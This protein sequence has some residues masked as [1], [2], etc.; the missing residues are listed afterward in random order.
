MIR[1]FLKNLPRLGVFLL[2]LLPVLI[3]GFILV[4][5]YGGEVNE[6]SQPVD[7]IRRG[8]YPYAIIGHILG[9]SALLLLGYLQFSNRLRI[10]FPKWHR[11]V[12]RGLVAAGCYLALSGLWMN[13]SVQAQPDSWLHDTAQNIAAVGL[14]TVLSLGLYFIRSGNITKHRIWMTRA[15]ALCLGT[16]TQ[17][18]LL[19]PVALIFGPPNGLLGDLVFIAGWIV[20]LVVAELFLRKSRR[21]HYKLSELLATS[22]YSQPRANEEQVWL[23]GAAVGKEIL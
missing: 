3:G 11:W 2:A 17:T 16:G 13:Q 4:S 5:I 14:L 8:S 15:Y 7:I 1:S 20:N 23:N 18:L 22:D 10:K 6:M 19:L 21:P 9:G 12:G